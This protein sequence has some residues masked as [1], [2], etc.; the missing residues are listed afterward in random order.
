MTAF[1]ETRWSLIHRAAG[2]PSAESRATLEELCAAWSEPVLAYV[3]RRVAT[4]EKAEDVT[5]DSLLTCWLA[6]CCRGPMKEQD[7]FGPFCCMPCDAS[8]LTDMIS[9]QH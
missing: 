7:D 4:P 2:E 1:P 8:W 3:H 9:K 6:V 5:P